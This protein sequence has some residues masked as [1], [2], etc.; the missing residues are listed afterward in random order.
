VLNT[1]EDGQGDKLAV[2]RP[3]SLQ[4]RVR[5]GNAPRRLRWACAAP[6]RDELAEHSPNMTFAEEDE[7]L[8]RV[9]AKRAIQTLDVRIG[10]G[11]AEGRGQALDP[12]N[13]REP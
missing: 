10:I 9:L 2:L 5:L 13:F 8:E 7:V 11:R 1:S 4:L 6:E 3:N 12:R